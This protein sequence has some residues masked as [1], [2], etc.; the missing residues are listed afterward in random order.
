MNDAGLA[1]LGPRVS[2]F[3]C[4]YCAEEDF[5]PVGALDEPDGQF[6]CRSC[7]RRYRLSFLGLGPGLGPAAPASS[8]LEAGD[9][10]DS[11]TP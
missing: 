2:P 1:N 10:W 7:D 6:H 11:A 8:G 4:P 9:P 5:V 3:Y